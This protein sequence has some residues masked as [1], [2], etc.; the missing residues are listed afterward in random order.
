[1]DKTLKQSGYSAQNNHAMKCDCYVISDSPDTG[2]VKYFPFITFLKHITSFSRASLGDKY[3]TSVLETD[4]SECLKIASQ[5]LDFT[6]FCSVIFH[7]FSRIKQSNYAR[8][9]A[10]SNFF[11]NC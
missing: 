11:Q 8:V 6:L 1:M 5:Y 4:V 9:G 2:I 3:L 10:L 7:H